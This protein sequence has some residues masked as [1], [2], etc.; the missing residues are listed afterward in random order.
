VAG[1][2]RQLLR[3]DLGLDASVVHDPVAGPLDARSERVM[4]LSGDRRLRVGGVAGS[5]RQFV[6]RPAGVVAPRHATRR[7][8]HTAL[9]GVQR[10]QCRRRPHRPRRRRRKPGP[11]PERRQ[12]RSRADAGRQQPRRTATAVPGGRLKSRRAVRIAGPAA[13]GVLTGQS[14]PATVV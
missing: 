14:C 4:P 11:S 13:D 7:R 3:P 8:R 6:V 1:Q 5:G 2:S 12:R 10:T 9:D